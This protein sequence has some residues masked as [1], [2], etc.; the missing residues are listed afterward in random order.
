LS[1]TAAAPI[2]T[3]WSN[4][5]LDPQYHTF[6]AIFQSN[7]VSPYQVILDDDIDNLSHPDAGHALMRHAAKYPKEPT[8]DNDST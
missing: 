1:A 6:A 2:N 5:G 8:S 7:Y 3:C 4:K